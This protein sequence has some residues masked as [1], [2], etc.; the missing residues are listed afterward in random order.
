MVAPQGPAHGSLV[1][2]CL[3]VAENDPVRALGWAIRATRWQLIAEGRVRPV[4]GE[5]LPDAIRERLEQRQAA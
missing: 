1:G 2:V 3:E 4:P 5:Q